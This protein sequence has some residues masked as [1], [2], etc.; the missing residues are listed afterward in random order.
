MRHFY[1]RSP[2]IP[3]PPRSLHRSSLQDLFTRP[4]WEISVQDLLISLD[5]WDLLP[6]RS[7][8]KTSIRIQHAESTEKVAR[9]KSKSA[10]RYSESDPTRANFAEGCASRN[11]IY[12][13]LSASDIP[14]AKWARRYS[15]GDPTRAKSRE[16]CVCK[17]KIGAAPQRDSKNHSSDRTLTSELQ[18]EMRCFDPGTLGSVTQNAPQRWTN[19]CKR[20]KRFKRSKRTI[21]IYFWSWWCQTGTNMDYG[22]V[23]EP[24]IG[25]THGTCIEERMVDINSLY[26]NPKRYA[27]QKCSFRSHVA[28]ICWALWYWA[29]W[30]RWVPTTALH[31]LRQ[32]FRINC[33][34][35]S[36][37]LTSV[38][39]W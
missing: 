1:I 25:W 10:P 36:L 24:V 15:Q 13:R 33:L 39:H 34:T 22:W 14:S 32:L 7:L 12:P 29:P 5:L 17:Y 3:G 11:K 8:Q 26:I 6:T 4:L 9:T 23:D 21:F 31:L 38:W 2:D 16:G 19:T 37:S 18:Y 35:A 20:S 27:Y 28:A 30:S